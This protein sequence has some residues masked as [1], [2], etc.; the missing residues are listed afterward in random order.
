MLANLSGFIYYAVLP[1]AIISPT[2]YLMY[3][4]FYGRHMGHY[5]YFEVM[6]ICGSEEMAMGKLRNRI[7]ELENSNAMSY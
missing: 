2:V 5:N 4:L 3:R 7:S 1:T 6:T